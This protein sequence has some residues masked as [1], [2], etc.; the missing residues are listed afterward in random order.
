MDVAGSVV[1]ELRVG[2][3]GDPPE[4]RRTWIR[5]SRAE[6][7]SAWQRLAQEALDMTEPG[8]RIYP[9]PSPDNCPSCGYRRP[10]LALE[11]GEDPTPILDA[12]YRTRPEEQPE[13]GRL[14]GA[15]WG[16]S[17]GAMPATSKARE[18]QR[19]DRSS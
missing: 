5:R 4:F 10:C 2:E 1:T 17:R 9:T 13:E 19:L 14:G 3:R 7:V 16:L 11:A 18:R 12:E 8:L 6:L 15:T